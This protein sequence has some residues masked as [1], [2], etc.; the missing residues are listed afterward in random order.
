MTI[1][2][3][4]RDDRQVQIGHRTT[5]TA[6]RR[7]LIALTCLAIALPAMAQGPRSPRQAEAERYLASCAGLGGDDARWCDINRAEFVTAYRRAHA[8]EYQAQRNVAYLLRGSA[9]GVAANHVEACAWR[10]LIVAQGH[11]QV[12][13]S[14]TA[15]VRFDCGRLNA[16][17]QA[18]ARTRALALTQQVSL[19]PPRR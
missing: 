6:M 12:D 10:L 18:L 11:Q 9:A 16:Q 2:P 17:D 8:G 15:N 14:D 13:A 4:A 1:R 3:C 19:D 7:T 5:E